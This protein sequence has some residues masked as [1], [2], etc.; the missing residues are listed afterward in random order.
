MNEIIKVKWLDPSC[1]ICRINLLR[2]KVARE[3]I[4]RVILSSNSKLR[5]HKHNFE[6]KNVGKKRKL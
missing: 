1:G 6:K 4:I 3:E 5:I 2:D